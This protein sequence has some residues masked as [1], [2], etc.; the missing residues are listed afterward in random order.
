MNEKMMIGVQGCEKPRNL[1]QKM[2]A[3]K[4][5]RHKNL[6]P[7]FAILV[8]FRGY[9]VSDNPLTRRAL[10]QSDQCRV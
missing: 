3:K 2:A 7:H 5:K 6:N 1:M 10:V 8:L 9:S 4:R